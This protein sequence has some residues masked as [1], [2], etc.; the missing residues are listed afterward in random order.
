M[1]PPPSRN[2]CHEK[3]PALSLGMQTGAATLEISQKVSKRKKKINQATNHMA[4]LYYSWT[5]TKGHGSLLQ[6]H[7]YIHVHCCSV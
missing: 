2:G 4:Q 6:K 7:L 3:L 1:P 5:Y